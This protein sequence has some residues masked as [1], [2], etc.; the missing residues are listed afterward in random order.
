MKDNRNLL[1]ATIL[2]TTPGATVLFSYIF[3]TLWPLPVESHKDRTAL[4][5]ANLPWFSRSTTRR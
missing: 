1:L 5:A 2:A 3:T 4:W